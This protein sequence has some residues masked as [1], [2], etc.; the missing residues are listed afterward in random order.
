MPVKEALSDFGKYLVKESRKNLTRKGKRDRGGLYDS[1]DYEVKVS[2]NSFEF[3]FLMEDYG[4]FQDQGVKGKTSS[5]KAPKSPFKFGTGT[6]KKGG[7]TKAM[8]SW[9]KRK[10]IRFR[11]RKSGQFMS[12]ESTAFV[13]AR[14]IYLTGIEPTRFYSRPFE[15]G[16]KR[17]PN[18]VVEAYGLEIEKFL[19]QSTK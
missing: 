13:I 9:V 1:L 19:K 16:F 2:K 6:G 8:Q 3:T 5:S 7:L 4:P 10:G 14:S 18:K 15:L 12:Y 17:L 11:N